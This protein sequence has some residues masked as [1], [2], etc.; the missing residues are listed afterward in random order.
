[1]Y[2]ISTLA[3]IFTDEWSQDVLLTRFSDVSNSELKCLSTW[4]VSELR[5]ELWMH[6]SLEFGVTL[7]QN[8]TWGPWFHVYY[9]DPHHHHCRS[10]LR[11]IY[12]LVL[13]YYRKCSAVAS[14]FSW[15]ELEGKRV[16]FKSFNLPLCKFLVVFEAWIACLY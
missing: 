3:Y 13:L 11:C 15:I 7:W 1:M 2:T 14:L 16:I 5:R 9:N 4:L 12:P 8:M 6:S 10:M